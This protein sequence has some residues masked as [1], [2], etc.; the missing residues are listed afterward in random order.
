[1]VIGT[2]TVNPDS[3]DKYLV[4]VEE[5]ETL[6]IGRKPSPDGKRKLV[7]PFPEVSG[8]HAEIRCKSSGWTVVD[9]GSTN[10][11]EVNGVR[12]T[13]GREHMLN[14][15][16]KICIAQY[17]IVVAPTTGNQTEEVSVV[18]EQDKTHLR[19]N[20]INAT[21]L[22]GDIK[23]F[24]SL[25]EDYADNPSVVMQAAQNVFEMLSERI[26][27][28]YG[29]VEKIA[30]DAIMAYW[31]GDDSFSGASMQAFQACKTALDLRDI[32]KKLA[33]DTR[34][35]PFKDHPLL[36]DMALATGPVAAG[37]IGHANANTSLLGDTANLVFRL[38]KLIKDDTIG[39]I[40]VEG[41]TYTMA[42]KHFQFEPLGQ[43]NVKGRQRAVDVYRLLGQ[44]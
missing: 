25:M 37:A 39:D 23:G 32:I 29:Q 26:T 34:L 18:E 38:E 40:V 15:G 22:V 20:L 2:I 44:L 43:F 21:I 31:Q 13:P 12:L 3:P 16:D 35:W 30:G 14:P 27:K 42:S 8:R 7:L 9:N 19:I 4:E 6:E 5:G 24:T 28:Q 17:E 10:G 36:L 33:K 1:M 41:Q 11:T